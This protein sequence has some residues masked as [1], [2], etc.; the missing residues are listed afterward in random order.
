M[1]RSP[2]KAQR[3]SKNPEDDPPTFPTLSEAFKRA[4]EADMHPNQINKTNS[5][6]NATTSS[7][8]VQPST[9]DQ[10]LTL[11][12]ALHIDDQ[13][14][15]HSTLDVTENLAPIS[16][17]N[18]SISVENSAE[19]NKKNKNSKKNENA[20]SN[21]LSWEKHHSNQARS[22]CLSVISEMQQFIAD[23]Q[24]KYDLSYIISLSGEFRLSFSSFKDIINSLCKNIASDT[25]F[26]AI[27]DFIQNCQF[28][29]GNYKP[30][31][32]L[33]TINFTDTKFTLKVNQGSSISSEDLSRLS[34]LIVQS[35]SSFNEGITITDQ[36]FKEE[37]QLVVLKMTLPEH[38]DPQT[39][40]KATNK[41]YGPYG[42]IIFQEEHRKEGPLITF[43]KQPFIQYA[44][45]K[46]TAKVLPPR[47]DYIDN[48]KH[49]N[50]EVSTT[51][52]SPIRHC[53]YCRSLNHVI[54]KCPLR[55]SCEKCNSNHRPLF[56]AARTESEQKAL[57]ELL[58]SLLQ[59]SALRRFQSATKH[60]SFPHWMIEKLK[61]FRL[62]HLPKKVSL[63]QKRQKITTPSEIE[64]ES[65]TIFS[66]LTDS[67]TNSTNGASPEENQGLTATVQPTQVTASTPTR[68]SGSANSSRLLQKS[69]IYKVPQLQSMYSDAPTESSPPADQDDEADVPPYSDDIAMDD[70]YNYT[71]DDSME[72]DYTS[73][74][75]AS[76]V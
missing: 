26:K 69:P 51:V 72:D 45:L 20:W 57:F 58:P 53:H 73:H 13:N 49:E 42:E 16:V 23:P 46:C 62:H 48:A 40:K 25:F 75:P 71:S 76:Y 18:S 27:P 74:P 4:P 24:H 32:Q 38:V 63:P 29:I 39:L 31:T 43:G 2:Y 44:V 37:N 55:P 68:S 3:A 1:P 61:E 12:T 50:C 34:A 10:S 41:L 33:S 22:K 21:P 56:C 59:T 19:K 70:T 64:D 5:F 67:L 36:S 15:S 28:R 8:E 47:K 66:S 35:F 54:E 11:A 17:A 52:S 14:N 60:R 65:D 7:K 30:T 6:F 9:N